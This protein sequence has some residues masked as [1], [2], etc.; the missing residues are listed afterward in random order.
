MEPVILFECD[1]GEFFRPRFIF[2]LIF[3]DDFD[4][5]GVRDDDFVFRYEELIHRFS[6]ID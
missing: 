6:H 5:I 3:F 2:E 4:C 1:N